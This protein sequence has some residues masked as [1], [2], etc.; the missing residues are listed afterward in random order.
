MMDNVVLDRAQHILGVG[1]LGV[2]LSGVEYI[3]RQVRRALDASD[4]PATWLETG[5]RASTQAR[6]A[7]TALSLLATIRT[8]ASFAHT[9]A[10]RRPSVIYAPLSQRGPGLM[11]DAA[12]TALA[13]A[14]SP[15]A[16]LVFHL[17]GEFP[18]VG[19]RRWERAVHI[20]LSRLKRATYLSCVPGHNYFG[21]PTTHVPNSLARDEYERISSAAVKRASALRLSAIV[22]GPFTREKGA[23]D[24][25]HAHQELAT[26][27]SWH[28]VLSR[29]PDLTA[30]T[31]MA[32]AM[33]Y[34]K[35]HPNAA[36]SPGL[37]GH[38]LLRALSSATHLVLPSRS[39]GA[40]ILV[41][42]ALAMGLS[43][44]A[45]AVGAIPALE[46]DYPDRMT[47]FVPGVSESLLDALRAS[48]E[49]ELVTDPPQLLVE[50]AGWDVVRIVS[51]IARA[52]LVGNPDWCD[53]DPG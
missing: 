34:W 28:L 17:H 9:L 19:L 50:T 26:D 2:G 18:Q 11:R 37:Y 27:A 10:R 14:L 48:F 40:P 23:L 16:R 29:V 30:D 32:S 33:A 5:R 41:L 6:G 31:D 13:L 39:E 15:R 3:N 25:W 51:T 22:V 42:E 46:R 36:V 49:Q 21:R 38:D 24:L 53:G 43:I 52:S 20:R 8:L 12:L 35:S 1:A 47:T 45:P 7:V 44:V 4:V